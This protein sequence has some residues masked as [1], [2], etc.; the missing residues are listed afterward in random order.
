MREGPSEPA[1]RRGLQP[2]Q[3][4]SVKS[5]GG[6]RCG[7]GG[8]RSR[9]VRYG[10][11]SESEPPMT[12]RNTTDGVR[13]GEECRPWDKFGRILETGPCGTRLVG[14]VSPYQALVW[15]VGTCRPD[16]KGDVQ[17]EAPMRTRVPMRGTGA[18]QPVIGKKVL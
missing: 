3:A 6:E 12:C 8:T 18:E 14:G 13:T 1:I 9:Q 4:A 7:K 11:T 2:P 10:K 15:N 17:V 5:R 16:A